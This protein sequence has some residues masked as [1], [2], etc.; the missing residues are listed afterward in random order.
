MSGLVG[1]RLYLEGDMVLILQGPYTSNLSWGT[2]GRIVHVEDPTDTKGLS[3]DRLFQV[4]ILAGGSHWNGTVVP[5]DPT[6]VA[7]LH[8]AEHAVRCVRYAQETLGLTI[9][10]P[11]GK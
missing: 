3:S 5:V 7:S 9:E 6:Q 10:P 4:E 11:R 8:E 2:V 1:N